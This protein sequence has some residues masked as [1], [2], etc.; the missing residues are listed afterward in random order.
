MGGH[1][2]VLSLR[3]H[4]SALLI[5]YF[6]WHWRQWGEVG[7]AFLCT[8]DRAA[9]ATNNHTNPQPQYGTSTHC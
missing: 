1:E 9:W 5:I 7:K 8:G 6:A 4:E 2:A 3:R